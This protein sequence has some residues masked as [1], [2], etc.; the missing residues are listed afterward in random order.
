LSGRKSGKNICVT[1]G[2]EPRISA[3]AQDIYSLSAVTEI[4][5]EQA[6]RYIFVAI[7]PNYVGV[8]QA[9]NFKTNMRAGFDP[10]PIHIGFLVDKL[11]LGQVTCREFRTPP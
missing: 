2:Y 8:A 3:E 10:K 1:P 4:K 9:V 11:A 5:I 6:D 7:R